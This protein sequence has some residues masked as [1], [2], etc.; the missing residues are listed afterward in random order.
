VDA[1]PEREVAPSRRLPIPA[2]HETTIKEFLS[3]YRS[4]E[5]I[6]VINIEP[7]DLLSYQLY[8][9]TDQADLHAL[10]GADWVR[11]CL[12]MER[13]ASQLQWCNERGLIKVRLPHAEHM[14]GLRP[15]GTF[16]IQQ[17]GN[18]VSVCQIERRIILKA[19]YHRSF[20]FLRDRMNDPDARDISLLVVL[21][22][23]LPPQ[24]CADF[25]SQ[26]LRAAVLG[27]RPPLLLDFCNADLAMSVMLRKKR[28]EMHIQANLV[29]VD[30][31]DE[32]M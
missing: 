6:D 23:S 13:P 29:A 24:L 16:R 21:T 28:F 26:S 25:P 31:E 19:G 22:K 2:K 12:Q 18:C 5:T 3:R 9:I 11:K 4:P 20:A 17:M 8:L 15:D 27:S 10:D 14:F 32:E 7:S 1:L 30:E